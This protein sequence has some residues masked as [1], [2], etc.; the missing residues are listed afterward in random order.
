MKAIKIHIA[1]CVCV[2]IFIKSVCALAPHQKGRDMD[3]SDMLINAYGNL[4]DR[5]YAELID[6][7]NYVIIPDF[8]PYSHKQVQ[9]MLHDYVK[10]YFEN[11]LKDIVEY[12]VQDYGTTIQ[13]G[14]SIEVSNAPKSG[15]VSEEGSARVKLFL[16]KDVIK[17]ANRRLVV[18]EVLLM[19]LLGEYVVAMMLDNYHELKEDRSNNENAYYKIGILKTLVNLDVFPLALTQ[20]RRFG[21]WGSDGLSLLSYGEDSVNSLVMLELRRQ[22]VQYLPPQI[23]Q[24]D[25]RKNLLSQR[26]KLDHPLFR[27]GMMLF[28]KKLPDETYGEILSSVIKVKVEEKTSI[29]R[30]Q[31]MILWVFFNGITDRADPPSYGDCHSRTKEYVERV[32]SAESQGMLYRGIHDLLKFSLNMPDDM[33]VD[34]ITRLLNDDNDR[35]HVKGADG[36]GINKMREWKGLFFYQ[37]KI[38]TLDEIKNTSLKNE[39]SDREEKAYEIQ[40]H[41]IQLGKNIARL[42]RESFLRRY[43]RELIIRRYGKKILDFYEMFFDGLSYETQRIDYALEPFEIMLPYGWDADNPTNVQKNL[44]DSEERYDERIRFFAEMA[45]EEIWHQD[46]YLDFFS[47]GNT[48]SRGSKIEEHEMTEQKIKVEKLVRSLQGI[49]RRHNDIVPHEYSLQLL[50]SA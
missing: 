17:L 28:M 24:S 21:D 50:K 48:L 16:G 40:E 38:P 18:N 31:D 10:F 7:M 35:I 14:L 46:W 13:E 22:D 37:L 45:Y 4:I 49:S 29:T 15:V 30:F 47:L 39:S 25:M 27:Y 33:I 41:Y 36:V 12:F 23:F 5:P 6:S 8:A 44:E 43:M 19:D 3:V 1:L 26:F 42:N 32:L 9:S 2:F 34:E 11:I 20:A